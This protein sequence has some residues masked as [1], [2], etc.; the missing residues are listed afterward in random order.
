MIV[1]LK[2][3][4]KDVQNVNTAT[5]SYILPDLNT[6]FSVKRKEVRR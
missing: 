6:S 1:T 4:G 2:M 5:Y 3:D